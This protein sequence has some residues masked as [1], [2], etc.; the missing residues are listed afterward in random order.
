MERV[1]VYPGTFDPLTLGHMDIIRRGAKL[2]DRLVVG[3]STNPSKVPM[4]SVEER[5]AMIR[6][7]VADVG[8]V[9]FRSRFSL[10]ES[11]QDIEAYFAKAASAGVATLAVGG[12]HSISLPILKALGRDRPL[13]LLHIDAH[14]DTS[15]P[16]EGSKFHHGGPFRQAVLDGV[17]DPERVIQIGI[18]GGAEY[19]WEF[20]YESGMTVI[21]ADEVDG[22]GLE[23]VIAKA[24]TVTQARTVVQQRP[25][26]APDEDGWEEF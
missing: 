14:C 19:L 2:V 5:L 18:R 4:F 26:S 22:L 24:R 25:A 10:E 21:H 13:G 17:L 23:A 15:G 11:H 12:D 16:Y 8:D 1:G 7:E 3:L 9:P 6:R 20:S